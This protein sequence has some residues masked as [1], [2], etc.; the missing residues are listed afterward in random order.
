[1]TTSSARPRLPCALSE[2]LAPGFVRDERADRVGERVRVSRRRRDGRVRVQDL[3]VSGDVRRD[4]RQ[5][6]RERSGEHHPEALLPERGRDEHLRPEEERR[7]QLV[8]APEADD[9][10]PVVRNPQPRGRRRTASGSTPATVSRRPERRWISGR[11]ASST[12][13][14]FRGL[15]SGEDDPML[16]S[17]DRGRFGHEHPVGDDLVSPGSHRFLRR[18]CALRDRDPVV[19]ALGQESPDGLPEPHPAEVARRIEWKVPTIGVL[20]STSA[21]TQITGVMGSWR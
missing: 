5:A 10:D 1:M 15:P 19:E 9:V 18:P 12:W 14:P 13:S 4:G 2:A 6:A 3:P 8:L 16:P 21:A 11:A 20:A 17:A 7:G